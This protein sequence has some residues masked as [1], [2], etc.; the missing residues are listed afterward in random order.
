MV[1]NVLGGVLTEVFLFTRVVQS[2]VPVLRD[3]TQNSAVRSVN[4]GLSCKAVQ[5]AALRTL[6]ITCDLH[7][8]YLQRNTPWFNQSN[9]CA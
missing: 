9:S 3:L 7:H 4:R 6:K 1:R 8:F 5:S 2:P